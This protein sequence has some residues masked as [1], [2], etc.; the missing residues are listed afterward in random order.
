MQRQELSTIQSDQEGL[1]NN[2]N[3]QKKKLF[4]EYYGKI[5]RLDRTKVR[6]INGC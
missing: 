6:K 2:S 5:Y 3:L 1:I 4:I